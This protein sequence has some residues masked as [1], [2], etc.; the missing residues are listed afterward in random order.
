MV[1]YIQTLV[2]T[3]STAFTRGTQ[4]AITALAQFIPDVIFAA[5]LFVIG[6]GAAIVISKAVNRIFKLIDLEKIVKDRR[7]SGAL[8]KATLSNVLEKLAKY[9]VK[10][11]FLQ[12][13]IAM[14]H[15]GTIST[16]LNGLA[17]LGPVLVGAGL[18]VVIAALAG[19]LV[20]IRIIEMGKASYL[21]VVGSAGK[22]IIIFL[23]LVSGLQT[24]KVDVTIFQ[25]TFLTLLN[26]VVLAIGLAVAIA[27]GLGGQND[28]KDMIKT[29]RTKLKF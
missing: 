4:Q 20:K 9:Y 1:D 22:V 10:L 3:L 21:E 7:L 25:Q 14:L 24:M 29:M 27:F 23:G 19:E 12:T 11:V 6:W 8:G 2:N 15:L 18:L 5:V 28:A 16:F 13:S 26:G 17:A